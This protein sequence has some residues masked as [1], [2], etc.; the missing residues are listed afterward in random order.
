M[1]RLNIPS[2]R[3]SIQNCLWNSGGCGLLQH[4]FSRDAKISVFAGGVRDT[5]LAQERGYSNVSPRDWDIG[6][7]HISRREFDGILKEVGGVRNKYGGFKLFC[8]SSQPWEIWR[9]E[10]TVGLCKNNAPYSFENVLRSFVLS[11]NAIAIDL[12][13]GHIY[14]HG[15]L[16]SIWLCEV[17]ILEDAIMHDWAVF[18]AKALSLTFRRPFR[19]ST[20]SAMF[21]E[22]NLDAANMLHEFKKAYSRAGILCDYDLDRQE[23]CRKSI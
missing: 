20:E 18:S 10:D 23:T 17:A 4:L 14:D 19:L 8:G 12:D 15:A 21:V 3:D 6:I 2:V 9:Q 5:I 11:C 7:S 13:K 16:R 1:R 22:K